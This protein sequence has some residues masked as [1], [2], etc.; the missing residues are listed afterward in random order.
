MAINTRNICWRITVPRWCLRWHNKEA[1]QIVS[2]V[3]IQSTNDKTEQETF[4]KCVLCIYLQSKSFIFVTRSSLII[5]FNLA[6]IYTICF[7]WVKVTLSICH[8]SRSMS[9]NIPKGALKLDQVGIVYFF[10]G[11]CTRIPTFPKVNVYAIFM[12]HLMTIKE[13]FPFNILR[14]VVTYL[15]NCI[16][17]TL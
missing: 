6:L 11:R 8:A 2:I 15:A 4:S 14:L 17:N 12:L 3:Q 9:R 10:V 1:C 16:K 7:C 13:A 5:F